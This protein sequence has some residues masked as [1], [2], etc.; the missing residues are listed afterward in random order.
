MMLQVHDAYIESANILAETNPMAAVEIYCKFPT[1]ENPTFD[2]AYIF[3]EIVLLLAK[4]EQ[5]DDPRL[6]TNLIGMGRVMGLGECYCFLR[7]RLTE[8]VTARLG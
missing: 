4:Q 2:D 5:F 7:W 1:S 6:E 8:S 3:G